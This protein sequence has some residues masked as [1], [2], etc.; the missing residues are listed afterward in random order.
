MTHVEVVARR[1]TPEAQ[2]RREQEVERWFQ[3]EADPDS[4]AGKVQ[5][6]YSKRAG[7]VISR[8]PIGGGRKTQS[9][10]GEPVAP[11]MG[12][13]KRFDGGCGT[14][15]ISPFVGLVML[16]DH[17]VLFQF[18]P[19]AAEQTEVFI[20]WLVDGRASESEVDVARMVWLWH[21]TTIQDKAIV[22]LNA[23]G[24]RSRA[25]EPGPYSLLEPGPARLVRSYLD[26]LSAETESIEG[27][28]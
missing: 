16:N 1:A 4:P 10:D 28:S 24:V 11:L 26:G 17:A 14:F 23:A 21:E 8:A 18:L 13:Q 9:E 3:E 2:A 19:T 27:G 12:R 5:P 20:N 15:G 22:E 7:Q 25:Y 6:D